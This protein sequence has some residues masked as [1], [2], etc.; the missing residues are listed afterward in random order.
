LSSLLAFDHHYQIIVMMTTAV[1]TIAVMLISVLVTIAMTIAMMV[2]TPIV[3]STVMVVTTMV[4][5]ITMTIITMTVA[6]VQVTQKMGTVQRQIRQWGTVQ[7]AL[8]VRRLPP[9]L[10]FAFVALCTAV[11]RYELIFGVTHLVACR[12]LAVGHVES[13]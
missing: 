8:A 5:T 2:I 1:S 13:F 9:H 10:L 6:T 4:T 3:V 11:H 7:P 12:Y